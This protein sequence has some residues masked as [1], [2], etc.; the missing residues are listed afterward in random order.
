MDN[1]RVPQQPDLFPETGIEVVEMA[2][3]N[4]S[5]LDASAY[6]LFYQYFRAPGKRNQYPTEAPRN[7]VCQGRQRLNWLSLLPGYDDR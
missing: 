1:Y 3:P 5:I 6:W 7:R 4:G 2:L